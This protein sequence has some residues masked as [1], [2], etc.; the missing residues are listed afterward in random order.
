[1]RNVPLWHGLPSPLVYGSVFGTCFA[2][3]C[4]V[5]TLVLMRERERADFFTFIV[6]LV[7]FDCECSVTLPHGAVCWSAVCHCGIT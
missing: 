6:F 4:L 5:S 3:H 2:I 1:M 7:S